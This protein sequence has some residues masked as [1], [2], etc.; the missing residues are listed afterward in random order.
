MLN[1][2]AF[3]AQAENL[4]QDQVSGTISLSSSEMSE[5]F[6]DIYFD[7]SK[8]GSVAGVQVSLGGS[9]SL[10]N[11]AFVSDNTPSTISSIASGLLNYWDTVITID[12][13]GAEVLD[14]VVS[15]V[16]SAS[17]LQSA[18]EN[19]ISSYSEAGNARNGWVGF[20]EA[21]EDVIKQI[22]FIVT[23]TQTST[24][25]TTPFTRFLS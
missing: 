18:L 13:A 5:A 7:Y 15:V 24:G 9:K 25:V 3:G 19:A 22:P 21:Q 23:E 12:P 8:E 16:V 17:G 4:L 10:L 11:G 20:F 14:V 1:P 6:A 2:N